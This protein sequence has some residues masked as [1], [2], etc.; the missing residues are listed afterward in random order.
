L[1]VNWGGGGLLLKSDEGAR[2]KGKFVNSS[3]KGSR[4]NPSTAQ[5]KKSQA[6]KIIVH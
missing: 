5:V 6:I 2:A 1:G 4:G 3:E